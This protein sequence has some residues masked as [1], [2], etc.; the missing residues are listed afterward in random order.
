MTIKVPYPDGSPLALCLIGTDILGHFPI[1]TRE[2]KFLLVG[3]DYF[4]KWV[5]AEPIAKII[6]QNVKSFIWKNIIC[7]FGILRVLVSNN[8][9]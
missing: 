8:E 4:T 9:R 1:R 2:M 3:I 6:E 7:H 5:E